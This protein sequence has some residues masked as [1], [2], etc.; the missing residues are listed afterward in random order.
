MMLTDHRNAPD[1][2]KAD[3]K[4]QLLLRNIRKSIA[5][6]ILSQLGLGNHTE[7]EF[8]S[9]FSKP[10]VSQQ[11]SAISMTFDESQRPASAA[12]FH[13]STAVD[14]SKKD[15]TSSAAMYPKAD[16]TTTHAYS[17]SDSTREKVANS[18][19]HPKGDPP[20][21]DALLSGSV[22]DDSMP[23]SHTPQFE[24]N[25]EKIDPLYVNTAKEIDEMI[26]DM[27]PHFEGKE[28]EQNWIAREKSVVKLRK[29]TRGNAPQ[30]FT[31]NYIAGIK[32]MLDGI[33]KVANSLRTTMCSN[34]CRLIDDVARTAGPGLDSMVEILLQS[35]IKL[36]GGTKKIAAGNGNVTVDAIVGN[37]SYNIRLLHHLWGACQ[38]KNVQPRLFVT[39]WLKTMIMKHGRQHKSSIEHSGGLEL[40]EKCIKKGLADANPGVREGM[41]G[42]YWTFSKVWPDKAET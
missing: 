10:H 39:G 14:T 31:N 3:L 34:G 7:P 17:K 26:R 12:S 35:L 25:G 2:A 20:R 42:T 41:R 6:S 4:K 22:L 33:L 21:K 5:N 28:T 30:D 9:S 40:I 8:K 1:R 37:V 11:D 15:L 23:Q 16:G 24:D 32:T 18:L 19:A 29:L 13:S 27:Q 38:D 36:C